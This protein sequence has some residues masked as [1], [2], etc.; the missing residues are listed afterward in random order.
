MANR[1]LITLTIPVL[2]GSFLAFSPASSYLQEELTSQFALDLDF[3]T[4]DCS[5]I[6][7]S[8]FRGVVFIDHILS[9]KESGVSFVPSSNYVSDSMRQIRMHDMNFVRVPMNW[10]SY[11]NNSAVFLA[12][13]ELVARAAADNDL[14]VI[15]DNHHWYTSS[16]WGIQVIGDAEGRG[17]PSYIVKDFPL[18]VADDEYVATAA[19]FWGAFLKNE[20]IVDGRPVWDVQLD[21]LEEVIQRVD[22]FDN[23]VGYEIMNE[24]HLF[25]A[26][27]YEDLGR[28]HTYMAKEIRQVTDKRIFFD[29][30]TAW[31]FQRNPSL[32]YQILPQNVSGVVYTPHLYSVP[33]EGSQ[34]EGQIKNFKRWSEEWGMEV[35][36]GEW[37]ARSQLDT[38]VFLSSFKENEFGWTYYS[39]RPTESRGRGV[40]LYDAN[41]IPATEGLQQLTAAMEKLYGADEPDGLGTSSRIPH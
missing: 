1:L 36:V 3:G 11:A 19:P 28:Y 31:G 2:L 24:P 27:Q 35:L 33:Y 41:W 38:D 29:R 22:R 9:G 12:E 5:N 37:S 13:V 30:E 32:E 20:I 14:C 25:N 10:E 17:F 21:Y 40:S 4:R 26:S 39:W 15:F 34:A 6:P 7:V 16:Y 18:M 8:E 23:V